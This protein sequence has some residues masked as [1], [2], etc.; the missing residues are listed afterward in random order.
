MKI[1]IHLLGLTLMLSFLFYPNEKKTTK[2]QNL[3]QRNKAVDK[4]IATNWDT[5]FKHDNYK[6]VVKDKAV[7]ASK[8]FSFHDGR[9]DILY[10][11]PHEKGP[12]IGMIVTK[13]KY[14][15]YNLELEFKW[16]DRRFEPRLDQKKDAGLVFHA[17][18]TEQV[19]PPSLEYQIQEGDVGD[20]WA[21]LGAHCEVVKK[22][23]TIEI[24]KKDYSRSK[25]FS[26]AEKEG[27]NK[28][29]LEVRGNHA[30]YYLNGILINEIKN[31]TYS[32]RILK[33]GYIGL[34]AEYAEISYRDIRIQE[35]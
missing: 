12:P 8:I 30:R 32:G 25:H 34:Q 4:S 13:K 11:W 2:A 26:N 24:P 17:V 23:R 35:L 33:S 27:W 7:S 18:T 31:A 16:G 1:F 6:F 5:L 15:S 9:V 14:S 21:L 20:L 19:W 28:V 10:D 29:R 22:G 3:D